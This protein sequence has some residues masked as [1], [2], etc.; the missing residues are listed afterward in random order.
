MPAQLPPRP[1]RR[2]PVLAGAALA[3]A[4][5]GCGP[6]VFTYAKDARA[7]GMDHYSQGNY[8]DAAADFADATRQDPRDYQSYYY[9]GASYQATGSYQQA[10]G[11]YR[12]C[13]GT[14]PMTLAGKQDVALH[15]R[16]MDSLAQCI[17]KSG[18]GSDEETSLEN[19]A[20]TNPTVDDTWMLAK[21]YRYSGQGDEAVEAYT[22]A[23]LLDPA[24]F[25]VAKE[26]GL[27]EEG[28]K[29]NDRAAQTLKKAYADNPNDDEVNSALQRLGVVLGPSLRD[30][31]T[32]SH[33]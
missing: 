30:A 12:S 17:A 27:Y 26:A 18:A 11:A 31:S 22:K 33:I 6:E 19:Q 8:V 4:I 16:A 15:Y 14:A 7:A 32:L 20:K 5:A 2:I 21:I 13:L 3:L 28:L 9:L 23:V 10:I 1:V 25:D 24:R 29:Q